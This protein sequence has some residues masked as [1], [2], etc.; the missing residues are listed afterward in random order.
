MH[1]LRRGSQAQPIIKQYPPQ[2]SAISMSCAAYWLSFALPATL[3][4]QLV[5]ASA[6]HSYPPPSPLQHHPPASKHTL[7]HI[8][9]VSLVNYCCFL[10]HSSVFFFNRAT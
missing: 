6:P 1:G 8:Q 4:I 9:L 10:R 7:S 3:H 5:E 2:R